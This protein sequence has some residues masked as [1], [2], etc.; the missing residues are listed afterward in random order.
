MNN[1]LIFYAHN[2]QLRQH[3]HQLAHRPNDG[4]RWMVGDGI[5]IGSAP[6]GVVERSEPYSQPLEDVFVIFVLF[7]RNCAWGHTAG[8]HRRC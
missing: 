5:E 6:G 7:T 4:R 2:G 8:C 3:S 1:P